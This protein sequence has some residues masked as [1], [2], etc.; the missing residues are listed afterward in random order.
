MK[1]RYH[2]ILPAI[3]GAAV[4]GAATAYAADD[5]AAVLARF[6][7]QERATPVRQDPLWRKPRKVLLLDYGLHHNGADRLRAAA[8]DANVVTV[9]DTRTAITAAVDADVIIG[10]NPEICDARIINAAKQLRWL[11]SLSAGVENCMNLPAETRASFM[12]TNMRG[13]DSPIVAE[14]AIALMLALAHGLDRFAVDNSQGAWSRGGRVPVLFLEG[15]TMLVSGLGAIGTEVAKRAHG[16]GMKVVA[17]RVGGTG[18]PDFVD[19]IGQPDELLTL[20]R[21]ADVVVSAVPLTTETTHLYNKAFFA[22]L[23]PSAFFI[24]IARGGSVD[25]D[26]LMVALNEGRLGGAGLDVT[27]PEPLPAGHP[28]WKSPR[29][30]ITPHIAGRSDFPDDARWSIAAENLRRYVAGEKIL[31]IVDLARGF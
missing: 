9:N 4:L 26:A 14:H 24:N 28:L 11:A 31:N 27:E 8:G 13:V 23:K 10:A 15:K 5:M 1:P 29:V 25:T 20:A 7:I 12:M 6:G 21:T 16:L 19:Y 18:K 2:R 17:T 3:I 22:V 30:L